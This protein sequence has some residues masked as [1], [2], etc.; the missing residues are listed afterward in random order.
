MSEFVNAYL[1]LRAIITAPG[2]KELASLWA[3]L[4]L[5]EKQEA[6]L[7]ALATAN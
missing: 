7:A 6:V 1:K 5:D 2:A 4:S 3:V